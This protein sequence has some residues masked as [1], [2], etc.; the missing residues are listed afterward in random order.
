MDF[1]SKIQ[2][3][4]F[5]IEFF[6]KSHIK[7][8]VKAIIYIIALINVHF[9]LHGI[10]EKSKP[11]KWG[12]TLPDPITS[13]GACIDN[14][15]L[16]VY[17]GHIGDAHVYSRA[18]HSSNFVRVD[19]QTKEVWQKL[20]FNRPVQ[21]FGMAA[22][23]GKIYL[24][25]GSQA[26][27]KEGEESNLS[28]LAEV[29]VFDVKTK[30]WSSVTALP[31]PRSSHE[32]VAHK[33]KLY[34]VGGWQMKDGKGMKW[35]DHGLVADL[36]QN[37]ITWKKLPKTKWVV[38]ANSAAVVKGNLYV[39]GGLDANGTSDAVRFLNLKTM[40]WKNAQD[41]PSTNRIKAFGSAST[42][43]AGRLLVSSFT[44]QPRIYDDTLDNWVD[45]NIKMHEKRFFHRLVPIG[46][47][48]VLFI[49]GAAWDG[50]LDSIEE[51]DFSQDTK[52]W[53][54][55]ADDDSA[56]E[57]QSSWGGFRGEGNSKSQTRHIPLRWSDKRNLLWRRN[58]SGYGQST[59]VIFGERVFTT[60]TSG[61]KSEEL[62]V[63]CHKVSNG[64]LL[65]EKNFPSPNEIER[66]QYVSQAAPSP[67]VDSSKVYVF[68]ESGKMIALSHLGEVEWE[69]NLTEEYGPL[70]GNH[71]VGSSLFQNK[72]SVGLLI[73][74]AGPSYLLRISK[75]N[76]RNDWKTD[77]PERVSWSTPTLSESSDG[78]Q[79]LYVSSNGVVEA[80]DFSNGNKLWSYDGVEGNTVA[81]PTLSEDLVIIG[82]S[83]DGH[84]LALKR[85]NL[86][87]NAERL[88]WVAEDATCS[89][90]SPLATDRHI[91]L[92]NRAGVATCHELDTGKKLWNL[93]LPGS[94]WASAIQGA[95]RIY[96][97]TKDGSTIVLEN[98]GEKDLL[99][100]NKL[101]IADRV[102]GV[103]VT[104]R[105]FIKRTGKELICV[106]SPITK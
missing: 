80:Y 90:S 36:S 77:R 39:I 3:Y 73:D 66:S 19:L 69:R 97:F 55:D 11:K 74:H 99:A 105:G 50:H 6:G 2:I 76:G 100:E 37:P 79:I 78:K 10:S 18:T 67:V 64:K 96:F 62:I 17:G 12:L 102:Y 20:P 75:S 29:F 101:S 43:L 84:C 81:S 41:F 59:P 70:E 98:N 23:K 13:F 60:S 31:A 57:K 51:L 82:S 71:G 15:Y 22:Y 54:I 34:I 53:K 103:A 4:R 58:I 33:G 87:S 93:R 28:S 38:R 68:F 35:H 88:V 7:Q 26:T 44:Y 95:G 86:D 27:N 52:S 63:R 83:K 94:C 21:G 42:N 72:E 92:V 106:G 104:D 8:L 48:K 16:Y 91:Y 85:G 25:G 24:A 1:F 61:K 40:K 49:G 56:D 45:T 14:N 9:H 46:Q 65:W 89:F 30:A 32:M 5:K 47:N